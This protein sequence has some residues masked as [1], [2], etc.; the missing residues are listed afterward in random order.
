MIYYDIHITVHARLEQKDLRSRCLL[1]Q[2]VGWSCRQVINLLASGFKT[3]KAI[4]RISFIIYERLMEFM[5]QPA[6]SLVELTPALTD[7]EA[8]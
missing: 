5:S 4:P 6:D 2:K 7:P 3:P 1:T 8:L